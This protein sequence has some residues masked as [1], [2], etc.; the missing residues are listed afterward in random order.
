MLS[1]GAPKKFGR[2]SKGAPK[3]PEG[4]P[5]ALQRRFEGASKALRMRSYSAA[6]A[7]RRCFKKRSDGAAKAL[8]RRPKVLRRRC[9]G[10]PKALLRRCE[11]AT[12]ALRRRC[13]R[14][15][16][17]LRRRSEGGPTAR[18]TKRGIIAVLI[19]D[20]VTFVKDGVGV[21]WR[22]RHLSRPSAK[23]K[24]PRRT[25]WR[26]PP[27]AAKRRAG[28][29]APARRLRLWFQDYREKVRVVSGAAHRYS[30]TV[31]VLGNPA[32]VSVSRKA[33]LLR[34]PAWPYSKE[35]ILHL[36]FLAYLSF[37]EISPERKKEIFLRRH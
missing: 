32:W 16:K 34:R 7:L 5:K 3:M 24:S 21:T 26:P 37:T 18:W 8:R 17:A 35:I 6:K 36:T 28:R 11:G 20:R 25:A 31:A 29:E 13:K 27:S 10:A 12:K 19:P 15:A 30:G 4:A 14:G 2:R 22:S 23:V 33:S 1:E 9:K